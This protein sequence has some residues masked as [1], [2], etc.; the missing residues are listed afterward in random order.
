MTQPFDAK[1]SIKASGPETTAD[2]RFD[3]EGFMSRA[4]AVTCL[5]SSV[6][7]HPERPE[8]DIES[9]AMA[10]RIIDSRGNR[11]AKGE[12]YMDCSPELSGLPAKCPSYS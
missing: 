12:A 3:I 8:I 11:E 7:V 4:R 1:Y 9:K 6:E 10:E 2:S 5:P